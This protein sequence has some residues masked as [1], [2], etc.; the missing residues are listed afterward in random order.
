MRYRRLSSS[1]ATDASSKST[2]RRASSSAAANDRSSATRSQECLV[3][4]PPEALQPEQHRSESSAPVEIRPADRTF[5]GI[6]SGPDACATWSPVA[7]TSIIVIALTKA[8]QEPFGPA[9]LIEDARRFAEW[10]GGL[11]GLPWYRDERGPACRAAGISGARSGTGRGCRRVPASL[12][13]RRRGSRAHQWRLSRV[14]CARAPCSTSACRCAMCRARRARFASPAWRGRVAPT[15]WRRSSARSP[16]RRPLPV[17]CVR[18]SPC[19]DLLSRLPVVVWLVDSVGRVL[20]ASGSEPRRWGMVAE[21][22]TRPEWQHAFAFKPESVPAVQ[23]GIA[24]G[25]RWPARA[26]TCAIS[27]PAFPAAS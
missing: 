2:A 12:P 8:A 1:R 20:H 10:V 23:N 17:A 7:S 27:A 15:A 16:R 14:S 22:R 9:R 26:S 5:D 11:Q 21:A 18:P 19:T 3:A 6:R 25:A 24:E 4:E 13:A